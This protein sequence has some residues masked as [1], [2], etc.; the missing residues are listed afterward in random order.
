LLS[1]FLF[2]LVFTSSLV[3]HVG[4]SELKRIADWKQK[5]R[6]GWTNVVAIIS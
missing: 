2:A 3:T 1:L 5:V 6:P 4:A